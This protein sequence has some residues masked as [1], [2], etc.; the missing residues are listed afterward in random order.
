MNETKN[1]SV[2]IKQDIF[3]Q[4]KTRCRKMYDYGNREYLSCKTIEY[5]LELGLALV[6][7]LLLIVVAGLD[8]WLSYRG[9]C[10]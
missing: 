10:R 5:G 2:P 1:N 4:Q 9:T 7:W 8:L 3:L 6:L